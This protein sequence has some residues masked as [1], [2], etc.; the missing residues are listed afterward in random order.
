MENIQIQSFVLVNKNKQFIS[1]R[2]LTKTEIHRNLKHVTS[3][4]PDIIKQEI[5]W[6]DESK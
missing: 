2:Q 6:H 5:L 1:K 4:Y 3:I